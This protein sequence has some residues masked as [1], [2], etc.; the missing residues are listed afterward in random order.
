MEEKA[1]NMSE[2]GR[3][4]IIVGSKGVKQNAKP[5]QKDTNGHCES[6]FMLN[7]KKIEQKKVEQK[8]DRIKK[9]EQDPDR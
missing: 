1:K 5:S 4:N 9:V 7:W 6:N 3:L 8:K 2:K